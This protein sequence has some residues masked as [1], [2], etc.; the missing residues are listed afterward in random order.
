MDLT[1]T[2]TGDVQEGEPA[3]A[4]DG[5][6]LVTLRP[7]LDLY[8]GTRSLEGFPT[9]VIHD[10][11]RHRFFNIGHTEYEILKRWHLGSPERIADDIL[12]TT[13]LYVDENDVVFLNDYLQRNE[14]SVVTSAKQRQMLSQQLDRKKKLNPSSLFRLLIINVRLMRPD[15]F[16]SDTYWLVR[17]VFSRPFW[18]FMGLLSV[19]GVFLVIRDSSAFMVQ[20][21]NI[22]TLQGAAF[23]LFALVISKMIHELG[24]AY[25]CKHLGLAVPK[26]GLRLMIILPFFYTDTNESWKLKSRRQ[27]FMIGAGGILAEFILAIVAM[28]LWGILDDGPARQICF[29]LFV[30]SLLSTLAINLTPFL[31]WDGYYMFSDLIGIPNLQSRGFGLGKWQLRKWLFGWNDPVPLR[32]TPRMHRIV[33]F[34]AYGAWIKRTLV[35]LAI[36][37]MIYQKVFKVLGIFLLLMQ[38]N[39]FIIQPVF[40]EVRVWITNREKMHWN[41]NSIATLM[42]LAGLLALLFIPWQSTVRAGATIAPRVQAV[43]FSPDAA[44]VAEI[45][46]ARN[47][48]VKRGEVVVRLANPNLEYRIRLAKSNVDILQNSLRRFGDQAFLESRSVLQ[49]E[50][51]EAVERTS[52]LIDTFRRLTIPAPFDGEVVSLNPVVRPGAWLAPDAALMSVADRSSLEVYGYIPEKDLTRVDTTGDAVFYPENPAIAPVRARIIELDSAETRSLKHP[53][54]ALAEGGTIPVTRDPREGLRP[55]ASFYRVRLEID[56]ADRSRIP[57]EVRGTLHLTGDRHSIA[58]DIYRK[59]MSV[60]IRESGF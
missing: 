30:T 54:M 4:Q 48:S 3:A 40:K 29:Y 58:G 9:Y 28:F 50:L 23:I 59:A 17:F 31:R 19:L 39:L 47:D 32:L 35:F 25:M 18:W 34:Y 16:L 38:V 14:L 56:A 46:V 7:D 10:R 45:N 60:L 12:Q 21:G 1:S 27:R 8:P 44:R 57:M 2:G 43:L 24:H 51:Q 13:T 36:G 41:R 26:F 37:F 55:T 53:M 5:H 22:F 33:L 6:A 11:F 15:R 52:G 49:N 20:V 42:A